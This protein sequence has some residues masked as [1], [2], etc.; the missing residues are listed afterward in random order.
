VYMV[1][2]MSFSLRGFS[3]WSYTKEA[4]CGSASGSIQVL[5]DP[6]QLLPIV[7]FWR[8]WRIK[9]VL[10]NGIHPP[11]H[12]MDLREK[13]LEIFFVLEKNTVLVL[14]LTWFSMYHLW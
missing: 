7:N 14:V 10:P 13:N 1:P 3:S 8:R 11:E 6:Q 9:L 2:L 4:F 5:S 12:Q